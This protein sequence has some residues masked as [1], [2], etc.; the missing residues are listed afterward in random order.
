[1]AILHLSAFLLPKFAVICIDMQRTIAQIGTGIEIGTGASVAAVG[2][3]MADLRRNGDGGT[4][5]WYE[6]GRFDPELEADRLGLSLSAA[7]RGDLTPVI[8]GTCPAR[9]AS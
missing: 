7:I 4:V 5:K 3:F 9:L 2:S 6:R 1:M 8:P